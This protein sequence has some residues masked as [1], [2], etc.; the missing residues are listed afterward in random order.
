MKILIE[1]DGTNDV[2]VQSVHRPKERG[3][4]IA[5]LNVATSTGIM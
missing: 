2:K 3:K 5:V 4:N 1:N